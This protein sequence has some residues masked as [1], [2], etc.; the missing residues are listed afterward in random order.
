MSRSSLLLAC[1]LFLACATGGPPTRPNEI[2]WQKLE[3][4]YAW[5]ESTRKASPAITPETARKAAIETKLAEHKK[6]ETIYASFF[7]RL[8][9]YHERTGD[10]RAA[11]LYAAEKVRIGDEY[12]NVLSR[13]DRAIAMYESALALDPTNANAQRNLAAAR[14]KRY[15]S[16]E[17]FSRVKAGMSEDDVRRLAG[18]PREDWIKQVVQNNRVFSVW[19]YPRSDGAASAIYFD[20]GVVYHTNWNAAPAKSASGG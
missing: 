8:E 5:I 15:M 18:M 7:E 3:T 14:A 11:R 4:D 1:S 16:L 10:E 9:E 13:F 12:M 6:L 19:I 17:T 20:A 2:E